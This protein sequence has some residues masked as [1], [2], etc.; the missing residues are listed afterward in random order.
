MPFQIIPT[1]F[2]AAMIGGN[3]PF[4]VAGM[5]ISNPI[6]WVPLYTPCYLL[7]AKIIQIEPIALSKINILEL[8]IHYVA[9]W[10]GCLIVGI[11]LSITT[12]FAIDVIWR[13]NTRQ[14]WKRRALSRLN[15]M[16]K[17]QAPN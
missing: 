7:G 17:D 14:R 12:H 3:L 6:T 4:A 2:I 9:L 5:F 11:C 10:L 13:F 1:I 15:K 16:K 8:G